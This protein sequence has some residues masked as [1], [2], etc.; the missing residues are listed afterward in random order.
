MLNLEAV[1]TT[2]SLIGKKLNAPI[3]ISSMTSGTEEART[4]NRRL[5]KAG[6][7]ER[8][9]VLCRMGIVSLSFFVPLVFS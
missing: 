5:T 8:T 7:D 3:L 2:L 6:L 9:D 1:D 4:I